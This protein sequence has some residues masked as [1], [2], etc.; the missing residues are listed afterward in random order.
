MN[1]YDVNISYNTTILYII[2]DKYSSRTFLHCLLV[3][4]LPTPS[5][6]CTSYAPRARFYAQLGS[7]YLP[8]FLKN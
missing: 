2:I 3:F 7:S 8:S 4:L 1:V 6:L 5:V